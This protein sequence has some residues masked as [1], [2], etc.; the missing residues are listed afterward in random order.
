MELNKLKRKTIYQLILFTIGVLLIFLTYFSQSTK[1]E[2]LKIEQD[3]SEI[4]NKI[5]EDN[6]LNV[7]EGLEYKGVD[8]NGNK[9]VIFSENSNFEV[10]KPEV[11]NMKSIICYF[12]FEDGSVLEIRSK[13][14][15]YNNVT[16]DMS[17]AENVNMLYKDGSL[18][19]DKAD[20]NNASSRLVI[21]GN[22]KGQGPDGDLVADKL[23]FDLIDKKLKISM[24]NDEKVNI[25]TKF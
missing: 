4:E 21:E 3:I 15:T 20:Y 24:N 16:L 17:F 18:F 9:F 23:N 19:S 14:G 8:K 22:V 10:D 5:D 2:N 25:K 12:Y 6:G 11:I 13:T 7:F 1:K